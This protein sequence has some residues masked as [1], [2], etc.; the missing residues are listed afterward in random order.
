MLLLFFVEL[1]NDW[2][3]PSDSSLLDKTRLLRLTGEL[4]TGSFFFTIVGVDEFPF[5][6]RGGLLLTT[7]VI[8]VD[9]EF[10]VLLEFVERTDADSFGLAILVM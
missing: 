2:L 3:S 8:D 7:F 1:T 5:D 10:L 6:V 4:W 9:D